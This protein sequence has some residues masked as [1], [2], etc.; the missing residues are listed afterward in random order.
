MQKKYKL[1]LIVSIGLVALSK[2]VFAY[3]NPGTGWV[4]LNTIWPLLV[5]IFVAVGAYYTKYFWRP[6]KKKIS[7]VL[8]KRT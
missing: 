2:S 4:L 1:L 5:A 8:K 3:L 6:I 7:K